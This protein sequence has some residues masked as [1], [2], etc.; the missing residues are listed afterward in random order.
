MQENKAGGGKFE[1]RVT[2]EEIIGNVWRHFLVFAIGL[3]LL[4]SDVQ[5]LETLPCMGQPP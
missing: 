3:L 5:K 2:F 4:K 1:G